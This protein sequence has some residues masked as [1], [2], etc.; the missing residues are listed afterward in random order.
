MNEETLRDFA[1]KGGVNTAIETIG[2]KLKAL[3]D[4]I[5]LS[6]LEILEKVSNEEFK[7][8]MEERL[9]AIDLAIDSASEFNAGDMHLTPENVGSLKQEVQKVR[10][11]LGQESFTQDKVLEAF[12]RINTVYLAFG[13]LNQLK[14]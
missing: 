2:A 1:E 11:I 14:P 12:T 7:T 6:S 5:D 10:D 3:Q 8:L 9:G 13:F 4:L